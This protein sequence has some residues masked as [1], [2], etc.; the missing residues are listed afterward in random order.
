MLKFIMDWLSAFFISGK[1][2]DWAKLGTGLD[3]S[4]VLA[5]KRPLS[6]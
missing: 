3:L 6:E 2:P 5:G 4:K 1:V